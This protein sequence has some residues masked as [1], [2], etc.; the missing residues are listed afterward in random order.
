MKPRSL[1]STALL[2]LLLAA[3]GRNSGTAILS[4]HG[5][6]MLR[7]GVVAIHVDGQPDARV[8]GDGNLSIDGKPVELSSDQ[9]DLLKQYYV[10]VYKIRNNGIATG[11]AGA[12]MAGQAVGAA[13][14]GLAHGDPDK[15]AADVKAQAGKVTAQA[16]AVCDSLEQLRAA[17]DAVAE[18]V[19]A[20]KPYA[21]LD[22]NKVAKCKQGIAEANRSL[23]TP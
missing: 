17:Q 5:S 22:E 20:F 18:Q 3:C 6:I 14:S 15:I 1:A 8:G 19:A 13:A 9:R 7:D 2:C 11:K 16:A 12:A 4:D 23:A 21:T 10:D